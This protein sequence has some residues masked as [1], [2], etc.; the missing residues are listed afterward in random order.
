MAELLFEL[1]CEELPASFVRR[2]YEQLE[3]EIAG[4]LRLA[5]IDIGL[6]RSIG[7][8]RRLIVQVQD[9]A[10]LQ[11][12][13]RRE[14]RG[15]ALK[16]AYDASGAPSPAL[17]GFCKSQGIEPD[18]L[19]KDDQYVYADK[20]IPGKPTAELLVEI[21]PA[22][23]RALNFDKSMRW[24]ST[25]MRFARP[26]R[27]LLACYDGEIVPFEIEG[28][29]SGATSRGHRFNYPEPFEA[30]TL[31]S[32]LSQLRLRDVEPDPA[33]REKLIRDGAAA[34]AS[35]IPELTDALV[36]ENVFLTEWPTALEGQFR[37]EF[38]QLP[39]PVL[40]TAMAK[41][42][43]FFPIR[44]PNGRLTN[45][46]VSI[47]NG[48][49]DGVV[50]EGNEWVLNARFNDAKF[51]YDEDRKH[52]LESFL[53][54]TSRMTFQEKLGTVRQ[55]ADRLS[56]L[57]AQLT[58]FTGGDAKEADL[59]RQAALYAKADLSTGLVSELPALQGVIGGR[60]ARL[61]GF[62]DEVCSA[63]AS[64]YA[65]GECLTGTTLA[66]R[67]T[68]RV[69]LA[70][71]LDKLAG[72]LGIGQAPSG[73]SDPYGL[74]RAVTLLIEAAWA[75]PSALPGYDGPFAAALQGYA[76]QGVEL[77]GE[78][79]FLALE[80]IFA[81]RYVAL[82]PEA[83][84]DRLQAALLRDESGAGLAPRAVRMR[85]ECVSL[86][87]EDTALV[88]TLTR[89]L[90]IVAAAQ[91]KG[92][93]FADKLDPSKSARLDSAEGESL[94]K[95]IESVRP[96][97]E[98]AVASEDAPQ[99]VAALRTLSAPINAFF[100]STMVMA[101]DESVRTAR[102]SLLAGAVSLIR[103]AGDVTQLVIEGS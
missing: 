65:P 2:A 22:A 62:P 90:N 51:F 3:A 76:D 58:S 68:V 31:P 60:Y 10:P 95:A 85:L 40:I 81:S 102:L 45:R 88:Q 96:A 24:G 21:L 19:R 28:I 50:R 39:D 53:D 35:G 89:P 52:T 69:S 44:Q 30:R 11:P 73:S 13:V 47:R 84:H 80:E 34:V 92:L 37:E 74:R 91:K 49:V 16:A 67:T 41:H 75:W 97:I 61:E 6:T 43:R 1:G 54:A 56:Q 82:I 70:D 98:Q 17:L 55:R 94:L 59:A 36:D 86:A 15:P 9:V 25:R 66:H 48:G 87:A 77:D 26:I 38:L 8:P 78:A 71:Q 18:Q 29:A 32:L 27:W 101:E 7:T 72:Y 46:F 42:E 23:V 83:P 79:A 100:D 20:V 63:I 103:Q 5:G 4:A 33:E 14:Q 12:D 93:A 64:H 57:A 99:V